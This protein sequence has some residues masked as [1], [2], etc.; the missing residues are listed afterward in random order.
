MAL[1]D[2]GAFTTKKS[3]MTEAVQGVLP[4]K[5]SSVMVSIDWTMSPEEPFSGMGAG[6]S[7]LD[8]LC[9]H[10]GESFPE[11]DVCRSTI[12]DKDPPSCDVGD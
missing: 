6:W 1:Y 7:Q 9:P 12:V 2:D 8:G 3:A 4:T 5:K 11:E 10:P